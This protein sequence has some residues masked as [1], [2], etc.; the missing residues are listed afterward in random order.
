VMPFW[1][2]AIGDGDRKKLFHMQTNLR[3]GCSIL[4]HYLDKE[5]GNLFLAADGFARSSEDD[6]GIG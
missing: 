3:Y 1:T 4:R 6:G 2:R 5:G